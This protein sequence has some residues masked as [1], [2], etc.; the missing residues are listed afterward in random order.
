VIWGLGIIIIVQE[1]TEGKVRECIKKFP[2]WPPGARTAND[3][4]LC[5]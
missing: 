1:A 3:T 2:D 4:A 5:H